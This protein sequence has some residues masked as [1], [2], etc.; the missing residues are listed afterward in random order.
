MRKTVY[1]F[2]CA[3][4]NGDLWSL[5]DHTF[6][7][8]YP[9]NG[10]LV[11]A[12]HES[13]LFVFLSLNEAIHFIKT[14]TISYRFCDFQLWECSTYSKFYKL[15]PLPISYIDTFRMYDEIWSKRKIK[16]EFYTRSP[17]SFIGV[18]SL[19]LQKCLSQTPVWAVEDFQSL[20][21]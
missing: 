1:K 2:V 19:R 21:K 3:D 4:S 20:I 10:E 16:P 6:P 18:T 7:V 9:K 8:R 17:W 12:P 14:T 5:V 15:Y 13:L 11:K